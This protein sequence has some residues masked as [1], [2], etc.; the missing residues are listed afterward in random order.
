[1]SLCL[2]EKASTFVRAAE[3][4]DTN[5]IRQVLE[6]THINPDTIH[7]KRGS[8]SPLLVACGYG[9]VNVVDELL[10]VS[11]TFYLVLS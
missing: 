1:M 9:Q 8:R 2:N 5:V 10:K 3:L 7:T 6:E 4:G 11:P